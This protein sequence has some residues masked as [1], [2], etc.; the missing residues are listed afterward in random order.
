[1]TTPPDWSQITAAGLTAFLKIVAPIQR[2]AEGQ[3]TIADD[4]DAANAVMG[5]LG[6]LKPAELP[7]FAEIEAAE[8]FVQWLLG[9][10]KS[11]AIAGGFPPSWHPGPDEIHH[12]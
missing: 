9:A 5:V 12:R 3:G 1:M 10:Y 11:G 6:V 7:I 4:F 8:P 2:I